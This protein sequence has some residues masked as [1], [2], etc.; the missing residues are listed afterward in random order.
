MLCALIAALQ[1]QKKINGMKLN[2]KNAHQKIENVTLA[3][4]AAKADKIK[5]VNIGKRNR[6]INQG[7]ILQLGGRALYPSWEKGLYTPTGKEGSIPQLGGRAL[8]PS[9]EGGLCSQTGREGSISQLGGRA[10]YPCR[11]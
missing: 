3:L 5:M 4:E 9:W 2:P 6:V 7:S 1:G 10:L 11:E 8:Y